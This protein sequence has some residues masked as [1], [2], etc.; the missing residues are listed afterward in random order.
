MEYIT[1]SPILRYNWLSMPR[2]YD[3]CALSLAN[4]HLITGK[5]MSS[6]KVFRGIGFVCFQLYTWIYLPW[7][8]HPFFGGYMKSLFDRAMTLCEIVF[9]H[10]TSGYYMTVLSRSVFFF[11]FFFPHC[12]AI[13]SIRRMKL[14]L[15]IS[16]CCAIVYAVSASAAGAYRDTTDHAAYVI[17]FNPAYNTS[18][19]KLSKWHVH[20]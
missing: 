20:A 10:D 2:H 17:K 14:P 12:I 8:M 11:L 1:S 4:Q 19:G 5:H 13:T 6:D 16:S 15:A 18:S 9:Y 3:C 7:I